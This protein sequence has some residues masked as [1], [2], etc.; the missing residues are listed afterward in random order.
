CGRPT[1]PALEDGAM[2]GLKAFVR[3]ASGQLALL[4]VTYVGA[5]VL[6]LGSIALRDVFFERY[7]RE[8]YPL[9]D[10][11][12]EAAVREMAAGQGRAG[13]LLALAQERAKRQ[14]DDRW[15][16]RDPEA[17]ALDRV[18]DTVYGAWIEDP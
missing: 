10:A 7:V 5:L 3:S 2:K 4:A 16:E 14:T 1:G 6:A 12:L 18:L 17:E 13:G 8:K 9:L 15:G 11:G